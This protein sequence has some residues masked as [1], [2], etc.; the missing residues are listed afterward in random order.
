MKV[1]IVLLNIGKNNAK[2]VCILELINFMMAVEKVNSACLMDTGGVVLEQAKQ[3]LHTDVTNLDM[4]KTE[5]N[6]VDSIFS[7]DRLEQLQREY[8]VGTYIQP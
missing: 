1:L 3:T 5:R 2:T 6:Q 8:G 7:D 4:E